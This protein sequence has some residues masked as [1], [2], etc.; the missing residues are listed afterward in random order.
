MKPQTIA[1]TSNQI[2]PT[3]I[4]SPRDETEPPRRIATGPADAP[5]STPPRNLRRFSTEIRAPDLPV[6]SKARDASS[7]ER[8]FSELEIQSDDVKATFMDLLE[9]AGPDPAARSAKA[10]QVTAKVDKVGQ[11]AEDLLTRMGKMTDERRDF[12][13]T[14]LAEVKRLI[15]DAARAQDDPDATRIIVSEK[16]GIIEEAVDNAL[17]GIEQKERTKITGQAS[18]TRTGGSFSS[19]VVGQTS[20]LKPAAA[21]AVATKEAAPSGPR[22]SVQDL[23]DL[24]PW[25]K[26]YQGYLEY[27]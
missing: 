7:L 14:R 12:L 1:T 18:P 9:E 25:L 4:V 15:G 10:G 17:R 19:A 11:M 22:S 16:L 8:A 20:P 5:A 27:R 21:T 3:E 26:P 6:A 24:D 13:S 2:P 23:I